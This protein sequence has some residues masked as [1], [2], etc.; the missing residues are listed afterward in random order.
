MADVRLVNA[1][2]HPHRSLGKQL[3][4][5]LERLELQ[6]VT[7]RVEEEHGCLFAH[8]AFEAHVGFDDKLDA[9]G[10]QA[11]CQ[12]FP[13]LPAQYDTKMWD[14]YVMP[15]HSIGVRGRLGGCLGVFVYHQLVTVKIIVNPVITGA[16]FGEAKNVSVE[17]A[18]G[19]QIVYGDR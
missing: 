3:A 10:A 7:A 11:L 8:Q 1:A 12:Y 17:M 5:I 19:G 18:G 6:S 9:L 15:V 16:A 13:I 14:R 4:N 2:P